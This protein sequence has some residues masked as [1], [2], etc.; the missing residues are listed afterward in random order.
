M[1]KRSFSQARLDEI[2]SVGLGVTEDEAGDTLAERLAHVD[3]DLTSF[4]TLLGNYAG[5]TAEQYKKVG[6]LYSFKFYSYDPVSEKFAFDCEVAVYG[7]RDERLGRMVSITNKMF[8]IVL[9]GYTEMLK[10]KSGLSTRGQDFQA[11]FKR[12][13]DLSTEAHQLNQPPT[14]KKDLEER[15]TSALALLQQRRVHTRPHY[16]VLVHRVALPWYRA[17]RLS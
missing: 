10:A 2:S 1:A 16:S 13:L 7:S 4:L 3:K 12:A 15:T 9:S 8:G 5:I 17:R 11:N 14:S 6:H